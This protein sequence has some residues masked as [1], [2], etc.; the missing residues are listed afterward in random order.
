[1]I[2][3]LVAAGLDCE[4][5]NRICGAAAGFEATVF[6]RSMLLSSAFALSLLELA[7]EAATGERRCCGIADF[8]VIGRFEV[9]AGSCL[10]FS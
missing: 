1:L 6:C 7:F 8:G 9:V 2:S 5:F 3:E 10:D 4:V